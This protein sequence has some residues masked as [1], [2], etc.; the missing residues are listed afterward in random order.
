MFSPRVARWS[1][2]LI[3]GLVLMPW[4]ANAQ[5][6]V[7]GTVSEQETGDPIPYATIQVENTERAVVTDDSGRFE[8]R[9]D[10]LPTTLVVR[11]VAYASTEVEVTEG[12]QSLHIELAPWTGDLDPVTVVEERVSATD[13]MRLVLERKQQ[14]D[15]RLQ[16]FAVEAYNRFTISNEDGIV[17]ILETLTDAYWDAER[18]MREVRQDQAQTANLSDDVPLPAALF[19]VNLYGDNISLSGH[20]MRGVTHPKALDRYRFSIADTRIE[21]DQVYHDIDVQPRNRYLSGF[22]GQVTV[23]A[24]EYVLTEAV[25]TPGESFLFPPPV[26]DVDITYRQRFAPFGDGYWLPVSFEADAS[27]DIA[28]GRLLRFPHLKLQQRS[29]LAGYEINV[30]VPDSLFKNEQIVT[31]SPE[32]D[33]Q[34]DRAV[35]AEQRRIPLTTDEERAFATIDTTDTI[36]RAFKPRGWLA[37]LISEPVQLGGA[38][39]PSVG[40]GGLS[41]RPILE[42]NRVE[43]LR[44]GMNLSLSPT[45]WL[46]LTGDGAYSTQLPD[47]K[48]WSFGASGSVDLPTPGGTTLFGSFSERVRPQASGTVYSSMENSAAFLLSRP[49]YLDHYRSR[50]WRGGLEHELSEFP[51]SASLSVGSETSQSLDVASSLP[52][53]IDAEGA[54]PN[55]SVREGTIRSVTGELTLGESGTSARGLTGERSLRLRIEH[56]P[57]DLLAS[58]VSFTRYRA[59]ARYR[60]P[61]LLQ[62]R[63]LP[64]TLD[65]GFSAATYSGDLPAQRQ[66]LI[67]V[68]RRLYSPFGTL[69]TQSDTP[70]IGAQHAAFFWEHNFRTLP[71]ELVGWRSAAKRGYNI[72]LF[73]G[74]AQSWAGR[75]TPFANDSAASLRISDGMHHEL[76]IS[77]SGILS[78]LRA[79]VAVRLDEPGFGISL[80]F[81]RLF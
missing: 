3:F 59:D 67:D 4:G 21:G 74:H 81:G 7:E 28:M 63:L 8:L 34:Q 29:S 11:H 39:T 46:S 16:S 17:S 42:A 35:V 61:T 13:V 27:I 70:Y 71:F 55:P 31:D 37:P 58:D 12:D 33:I 24:G 25:L 80:G 69:R 47:G 45:S 48:R 32:S 23:L 56:A 54:R 52:S 57:S 40:A 36:E 18:G 78:I 14:W 53:W 77:F 10:S 51:L 60:I 79:D 30:P 22:E 41:F 49:D 66:G 65:V 6:T 73:G 68:S 43:S 38:A 1:A 2:I 72:V 20:E 44:A 15:G 76:G 64:N 5:T 19:V 62:R 75:G 26:R 50:V 9:I